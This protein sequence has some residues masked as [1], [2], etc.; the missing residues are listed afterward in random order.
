VLRIRKEQLRSF[1]SDLQRALELRLMSRLAKVYPEDY[2]ALGQNGALALVRETLRSAEIRH[3]QGEAII[4]DLLR[5]Y[6]EF[7]PELERAPYREWAN[8]MLDQASLPGPVRVN[9]VSQR[10]F[11]HTQGRR[12]IL[13]REEE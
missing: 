11:A 10:L 12:I 3:V 1:E 5:L 9:L 7:G 13:H 6:V 4:F 8:S 2:S